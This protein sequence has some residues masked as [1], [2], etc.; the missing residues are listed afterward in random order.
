MGL[1]EFEDRHA[2]STHQSSAFQTWLKEFLPDLSL[3]G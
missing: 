3:P 2:A 1:L